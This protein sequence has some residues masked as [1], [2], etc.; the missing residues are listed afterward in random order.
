MLIGDFWTLYSQL[1][2]QSKMVGSVIRD[3]TVLDTALDT[4][5]VYYKLLGAFYNFR[6]KYPLKCATFVACFVDSKHEYGSSF[7]QNATKVLHPLCT[8][9]VIVI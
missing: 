9:G 5:G 1:A 8:D 3:L 2:G 7:D 6:M 4:Y